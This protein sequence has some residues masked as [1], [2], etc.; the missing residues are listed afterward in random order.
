MGWEC[1]IGLTRWYI[2]V[3]PIRSARPSGLN[4]FSGVSISVPAVDCFV[5]FNLIAIIIDYHWNVMQSFSQL[6]PI[7]QILWYRKW[8]VE[9]QLYY[10]LIVYSFFFPD[11]FFSFRNLFFNTWPLCKRVFFT[12]C[13][14]SS[15]K[16]EL[17][18]Y[19]PPSC[20]TNGRWFIPWLSDI[21]LLSPLHLVIEIINSSLECI[22][23]HA[24]TSIF[25]KKK[26]G[27]GQD[28]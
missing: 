11:V 25:V 14:R 26:S 22:F 4:R 6:N 13:T 17:V 12:T 8:G 19:Y 15:S 23:F 7:T 3:I 28:R 21:Q 10:L 24:S 2:G 18:S 5:S 27:F 1:M 20:F 16:N 9:S